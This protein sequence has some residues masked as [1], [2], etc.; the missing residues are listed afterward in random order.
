MTRSQ[1]ENLSGLQVLQLAALKLIKNFS[2]YFTAVFFEIILLV[3]IVSYC[4][5]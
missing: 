4:L 5:S 3:L 2:Y 1:I